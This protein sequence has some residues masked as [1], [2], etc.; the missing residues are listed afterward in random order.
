M[1]SYQS[2]SN[3]PRL[4]DLVQ[5][6]PLFCVIVF[7]AIITIILLFA[8]GKILMKAGKPGFHAIIPFLNT[9]DLFEIAWGKG[10]YFLLLLIP[11]ANVIVSVIYSLKLAKAFGQST[12]FAVGL[13]LLS[14]IFT[15]ALGFGNAEYIAPVTE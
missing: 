1:D 6:N 12:G 11:G 14:P 3:S 4:S 13:I 9:Y 15:M 7:S 10:I 8:V 5:K 2:L